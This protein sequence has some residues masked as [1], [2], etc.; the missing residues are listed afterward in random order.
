MNRS[1]TIGNIAAALI[2]FNGEVK[3]I[4]K[5]GKNPH[6]KSEYATL[7]NLIEVTRPILHKHGLAVMQFPCG[8]GEKITVKTLI[9]H[10]SGEWIESD[11][12]TIKPVKIDPQGAGS[13]ITY[14][15][16]YSY[17]AALS[18]ALGDDDDGNAASHPPKDAIPPSLKA[19][20]Q[21]GKGSLDG[22]EEWVTEQVSKGRSYA[23]MESMLTEA[24]K[25]KGEKAG[26]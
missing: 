15:R 11:P 2:A 13:A 16:R 25:K 23:Q 24:M 20:Y 7:D 6:F 4:A 19:K 9:L 12:L 8:D 26:A 22:F 14:A 3:T 18:L 10:K 1:D 5:D 17:A 21:L